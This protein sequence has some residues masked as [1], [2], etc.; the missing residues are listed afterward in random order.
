MQQWKFPHG[1]DLT[2]TGVNNTAIEIFLDTIADSL[3]REVI[4]NSLDAHNSKLREPVLVEFTFY[5]IESFKIPGIDQ[6]KNFALPRAVDMW[7]EINNEDTLNFLDRFSDT[8]NQET[9]SVLKISDYNT[10]GLNEKNYKS[11]VLGNA[12]SEKE[13]DFSS[14]S[15]GIGKAAPFAAS[16]LRMV[17]YN[18]VPT[19]DEPKSAG[20]MNFVSFEYDEEGKQIT[21][22]RA[23]YFEEGKKFLPGQL[24][25]KFGKRNTDQYGT[26]LFILGLKSFEDSWSDKIMLSV[27]NNFLISIMNNELEVVVD[28]EK[29]NSSNL[30]EKMKQLEDLKLDR[31]ERITFSST[32]NYY[33]VMTNPATLKFHLDD[34]FKKYPFYQSEEDATLYLLQHE[35]ANRTILQTRKAGM[36]IYDRNRINGNINFTGV[37]QATGDKFNA[38]LKNMENAN[39]NTWSKDRLS[40]KEV[41]LAEKLLLDLLHW[42]KEK[43]SDSYEISSENEVDAFGV[44]D[45]LPLNE[46]KESENPTE[47]DSGI[48]NKIEDIVIKKDSKLSSL[49]TNDGDSEEKIL[50]RT[51]VYAGLIDGD[52]SG[53]GG[54][55][56][57]RGGGKGGHHGSGNG[58]GSRGGTP[59]GNDGRVEKEERVPSAK[60]LSIKIIGLNPNEGK[61]RMVGKA[62][63][64]LDTSEIALKY[65]G[66]DGSSYSIKVLSASSS[67]HTVSWRRNA[68]RIK[69]IS[70]GDKFSI[71]FNVDSKLR[72]KMEG[73][74]YEIKG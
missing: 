58:R 42:Y 3:T 48:K 56:E 5:D 6:I 36:K 37:F 47:K 52:S 64:N 18:T 54:G 10:K 74:V 16:D 46:N 9:I 67:S 55:R 28:G 33:D 13:N 35:P 68:I 40:G 57:G 23:S 4:Q 69:D 63:K 59:E 27:V 62:L 32:Q 73:A 39:H 26:D 65:V 25:S 11:L 21:Q 24:E 60:S 12:Y 31:D 72:M 41:K 71:D 50:E 70:K 44:S 45:L 51:M 8:L 30:S 7:K 2:P 38:F 17:F 20:V 66:A 53:F 14:G 29:L 43:V 49:N 22:E 61:Y 19:E 1:E 34:R 15:K